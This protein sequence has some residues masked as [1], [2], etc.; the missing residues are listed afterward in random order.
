MR[1]AG[2]WQR[3]APPITPSSRALRL[4]CEFRLVAGRAGFSKPVRGEGR[5]KWFFYLGWPTRA[6]QTPNL[7][8]WP[9]A[10]S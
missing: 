9:Q 10:M 5:A 2:Q 4:R 6:I 7:K 3:Y 8:G 1:R